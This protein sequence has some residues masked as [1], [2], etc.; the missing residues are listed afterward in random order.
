MPKLSKAAITQ[1]RRAKTMSSAKHGIGG[2]EKKRQPVPI[3][4]RREKR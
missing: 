3:T 2:I 4:L 1:L